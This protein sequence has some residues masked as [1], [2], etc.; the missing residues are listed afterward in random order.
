[1]QQCRKRQHLRS[2]RPT[3][4]W[5]LATMRVHLG[6]PPHTGCHGRRNPVNNHVFALVSRRHV[7]VT[8]AGISVRGPWRAVRGVFGPAGLVVDRFS[9]LASSATFIGGAAFCPV[10]SIAMN[11]S[12]FRSYTRSTIRTT[13]RPSANL[14]RSQRLRR[15]AAPHRN[16]CG[17]GRPALAGAAST[18]WAVS[19]AGGCG[20]RIGGS[21][22]GGGA[23][24]SCGAH[25]TERSARGVPGDRVMEGLKMA[26][27][28][29]TAQ[30]TERLQTEG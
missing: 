9:S 12:D 18:A 22:R 4:S 19:S 21:A 26:C 24:A 6:M 8:P 7:R 5:H 2:L 20:L 10:R 15:N 17:C 11:T 23:D 29:L 14:P 13:P 25:S 3:V 27:V 1:M 28:A 16:R 30:V